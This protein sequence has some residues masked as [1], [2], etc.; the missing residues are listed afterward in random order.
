VPPRELNLAV[1]PQLQ[2]IVYRALERDPGNRYASAHDF[3]W[4]LKHQDQVGAPDR[5]ELRDWKPRH[6]T[7]WIKRILSCVALVLIPSVIFAL[8]LFVARHA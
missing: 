4:D 5:M 2:E 1:S 6:R 3:A 7:T 8:M